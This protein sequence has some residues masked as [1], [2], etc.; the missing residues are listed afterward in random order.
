M[1]DRPLAARMRPRSLEELAGQQ[2]VVGPGTLLRRSIE[3]DRISSIILY[4][5]A[6]LRKNIAGGNYRPGNGP[7]LRAHQVAFSPMW[8]T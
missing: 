2:H 4:G 1:G 7:A 5:P 6:R 8:P 3:A